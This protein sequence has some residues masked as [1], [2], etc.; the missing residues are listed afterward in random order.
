[1]TH[2]VPRINPPVARPYKSSCATFDFSI[3]FDFNFVDDGLI[4]KKDGMSM[5]SYDRD[6]AVFDWE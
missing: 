6:I 3:R 1:M 4:I 2:A 5:S